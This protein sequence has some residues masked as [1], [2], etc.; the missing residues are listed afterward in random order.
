[1]V[2]SNQ[3]EEKG[4]SGITNEHKDI[5]NK[6]RKTDLGQYSSLKLDPLVVDHHSNGTFLPS[7]FRRSFFQISQQSAEKKNQSP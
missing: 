1:M 7:S 5:L 3:V 4:S 2:I 6:K